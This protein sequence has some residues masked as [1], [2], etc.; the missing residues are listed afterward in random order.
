MTGQ[1]GGL[2]EVWLPV[3]RTAILLAAFFLIWTKVRPAQEILRQGIGLVLDGLGA[4]VLGNF[5]DLADQFQLIAGFPFSALVVLGR[6]GV[7]RRGRFINR[8]HDSLDD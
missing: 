2:M 1:E 8:R 7:C 3:L 4:L 6:T 5:A